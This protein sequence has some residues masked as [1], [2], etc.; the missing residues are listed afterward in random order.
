MLY[1]QIGAR[2][3]RIYSCDLVCTLADNAREKLG[4]TYI[5]S[6]CSHNNHMRKALLYSSYKKMEKLRIRELDQLA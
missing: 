3:S 5:F 6:V 4:G 2:V 1:E